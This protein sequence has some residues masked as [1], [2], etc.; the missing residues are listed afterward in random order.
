MVT[1]YGLLYTEPFV[2]F[3]HVHGF[4]LMQHLNDQQS[5]RMGHGAQHLCGGFQKLKGVGQFGWH[6][7]VV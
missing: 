7:S 5:M 6:D 1:G 3:R 4:L 2:D